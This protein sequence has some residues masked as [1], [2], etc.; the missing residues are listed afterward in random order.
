MIEPQGPLADGPHAQQQHDDG[1]QDAAHAERIVDEQPPQQ[2][3]GPAAQI[4]ASDAEHLALL[5]RTLQTALVRIPAEER[6]EN[7]DDG[8][9]TEEER[10]E[11]GRPPGVFARSPLHGLSAVG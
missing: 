4:F 1:D 10:H 8:E 5:G 9:Q 11:T 7:R 2:G 3:P 6:R